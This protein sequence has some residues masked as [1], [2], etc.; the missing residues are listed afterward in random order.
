MAD[1]R[2]FENGYIDISQPLGTHQISMKFGIA[3]RILTPMMVT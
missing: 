2:Y 1:G 3:T